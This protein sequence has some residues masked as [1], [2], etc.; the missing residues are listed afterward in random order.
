MIRGKSSLQDPRASGIRRQYLF[1]VTSPRASSHPVSAPGA[2]VRRGAPCRT[3]GGKGRGASGRARLLCRTR[4]GYERPRLV[5][6]VRLC[7]ALRRGPQEVPRRSA[8]PASASTG[9]SARL[10]T[11]SGSNRAIWP[12][13]SRTPPDTASRPPTLLLENVSWR[14]AAT[15]NRWQRHEADGLPDVSRRAVR[16]SPTDQV[17]DAST[18]LNCSNDITL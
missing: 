8:R 3:H 17:G 16:P 2:A 9:S 1:P 10:T 15:A 4:E 5:L 14:G 11:S 12:A 13:S 6:L 18:A 7:A